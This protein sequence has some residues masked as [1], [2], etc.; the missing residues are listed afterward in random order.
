[1]TAGF[2]LERLGLW[3]LAH[4]GLAAAGVL[5]LTVGLFVASLHLGFES[6]IREIFRSDARDYS[7]LEDVA[8]EYPASEQDV[9][10]VLSGQNLLQPDILEKLRTLH[11]E[12][13]FVDGVTEVLSIFSAREP[14]AVEG[15]PAPTVPADLSGVDMADFKARL[16]ANPLVEGKLLS[17]DGDLALL[18]VSLDSSLNDIKPLSEAFGRID[19][20]G[21]KVL[22]GTGIKMELTGL[23]VMRIEIIDA[24]RRDQ[25]T[26]KIAGFAFG[27]LLTWM[28]FRRLRYVLIVGAPVIAAIVW[29]LGAMALISGSLNVL[30]AVV[31]TLVM[32][33]SFADAL[34]LLF[35][36]RH[37]MADGE[38]T[39]AAIKKALVD[40][41][42]ACVLTSLTT[43]LALLSLVLVPHPFIAGF[44]MAGA[45]G[46]VIAFLATIFIF[47]FVAWFILKG[48]A[49]G[50]KARAVDS[51]FARE[52]V[53]V[54]ERSARLVDRR[55]GLIA[56]VS[57]VL[58]VVC[59]LAYAQNG[60][61]H[62]YKENLPKNNDAYRAIE[63]I[64]Q[65]LAGSGTLY[66]FLRWKDDIDLTSEAAR[67][68]I[69][70]AH[71]F[72]AETPGVDSVWSLKSI[73]DWYAA[74]TRPPG[75]FGA[76]LKQYQELFAN[77][78]ISPDNHS[79]LVTGYFV[80][81]DASK[82]KPKLDALEARL[83]SLRAA[84]PE[85]TIDVTGIDAVA[86]RSSTEMISQLNRSLA[87]AII[88]II[89]AIG[90]S[91]RSARAS[92]VSIL[93]NVMPIAVGGTFLWLSG[94]G[95]QFTSV[96][97][98]TISFGMAVDSTIH[99]LNRYRLET[100]ARGEGAAALHRTVVAVGPVLLVSTIV[101]VVGLG[102]TV[103]SVM[104]TVR[105]YGEVSV[106]VLT[107]ALVA[108]LLF[109][110]AILKLTTRK[111]G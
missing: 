87:A 82:L 88:V 32:V 98:F 18:V 93:P 85:V 55:S 62:I 27:A 20:L 70:N 74:G 66:L 8:D 71:E 2:G 36:V 23:P 102:V 111:G 17:K 79:A 29:Q 9:L 26:F 37:N 11:L 101:L 59:G 84:H 77:R 5:L 83:D 108:N 92:L 89:I 45:M 69:A 44:G 94:I 30:T 28:F 47:P 91:M 73:A 24:L 3:S 14:P 54:S 33:L 65:K 42:P 63:A 39:R 64:D 13:L 80:N 60:P 58:A 75:S 52:S 34:H 16:L 68:V 48:E 31:P 22:G 103:T 110:P 25:L 19:A 1:M 76:F 61:H 105:L 6:D 109:L 43:T 78:V 50:T 38:E 97:A 67:T 86:A 53:A 21:D 107:T 35:A 96:V 106:I 104:P 56:V 100:A 46:T 81:V 10:V 99:M 49:A 41:G 95:L 72:L 51:W 12:L 40:V 15:D 4:K 7:V 90:L 57:V